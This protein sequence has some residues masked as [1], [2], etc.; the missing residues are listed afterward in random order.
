MSG[1]LYSAG[2]SQGLDWVP[3]WVRYRSRGRASL[4]DQPYGSP[5]MGS[6]ER[7]GTI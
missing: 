6:V 2:F 7:D 4:R 1:L 3:P 5:S